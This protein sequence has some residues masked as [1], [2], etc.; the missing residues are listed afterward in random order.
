MAGARTDGRAAPPALTAAVA[1]DLHDGGWDYAGWILPADRHPGCGGWLRRPAAFRCCQRG[2]DPSKDGGEAR[3]PSVVRFRPAS[4]RP[5]ASHVHA[6]DL[7]ASLSAG[8]S[9]ASTIGADDS[10]AR[11]R[12]YLVEGVIAA[13]F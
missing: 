7:E 8:E 9:W 12:C 2:S 1:R 13:T 10:D 11:G 6:A 5:P 4:W 3:V